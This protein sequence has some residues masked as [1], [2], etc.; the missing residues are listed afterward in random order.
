MVVG[1]FCDVLFVMGVGW[2]E[3]CMYFDNELL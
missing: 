2:F 3:L 1:L